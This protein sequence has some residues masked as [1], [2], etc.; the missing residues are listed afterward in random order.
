MALRFIWPKLQKNW[1]WTFKTRV[2]EWLSVSQNMLHRTVIHKILMCVW[3]THTTRQDSSTQTIKIAQQSS[4][5]SRISIHTSVKK[6]KQILK[7]KSGPLLEVPA[8][9][10]GRGAIPGGCSKLADECSFV[11][12]CHCPPPETWPPSSRHRCLTWKTEQWRMGTNP[13]E[14]PGQIQVLVC[15][16]NS[17]DDQDLKETKLN[18]FSGHWTFLL[19][20]KGICNSLSATAVQTPY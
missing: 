9:P 11:V 14:S 10:E 8:W 5:L 13:R 15:M 18:Y 4:S 19:N 6:A 2:I 16:T 12:A 7:A 20:I 1:S 3:H 17:G